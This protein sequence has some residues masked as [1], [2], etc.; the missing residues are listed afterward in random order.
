MEDEKDFAELVSGLVPSLWSTWIEAS[1]AIGVSP[2]ALSY[3]RRGA[4]V[5]PLLAFERLRQAV[6]VHAAGGEDLSEQ[7]A[8]AWQ[9]GNRS[10]ALRRAGAL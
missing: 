5:P 2:R 3:W 1:N 7:V 8:R 9:E 4:V 6:R 10:K